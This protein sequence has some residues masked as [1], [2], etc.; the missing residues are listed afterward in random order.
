MISALVSVWWMK[1]L[2]WISETK[3]FAFDLLFKEKLFEGFSAGFVVSMFR[4][5]ELYIFLWKEKSHTNMALEKAHAEK[6]CTAT[7]KIVKKW[8]ILGP[9]NEIYYPEKIL[10]C[11][12]LGC[13][14]RRE[15]D[16]KLRDINKCLW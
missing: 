6:F 16:G 11:A 1:K 2:H 14:S 3:K 13:G 8:K 5:Y 4:E 12:S 9:L 7:K 15:R 10:F